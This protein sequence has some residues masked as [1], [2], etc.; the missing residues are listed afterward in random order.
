MSA[1]APRLAMRG[2]CK[3]FDGVQALDHVDLV[4]A[5]GS[6]HALMGENGA[7]KSTLM[8]VLAGACRADAGTIAID[9]RSVRIDTP[10]A[11]RAHGVSIVF[12]EPA[13]APNLRVDDNLFLGDEPRRFGSLPDR[14]AMRALA[15]PLLERLGCPFTLATRVEALGPAAQQQLE[16]ARALLHRATIL[17][18]DEPT[19]S[20]SQRETEVLFAR[21]AELKRAGVAIIYISHRMHEVEQLADRVSVLRD[22]RMAGTLE[23]EGL[24]LDAVVQRMVG[25][26]LHGLFPARPPVDAAARRVAFELRGFRDTGAGHVRDVSLTVHHGEVLGLAGLV[27][28]GR[29]ELARLVVG[30]DRRAAGGVRAGG[31][32]LSIR[33]PA[34][35]LAAGITYLAED[36]HRDGLFPEMSVPDNLTLSVVD[37]SARLGCLDRRRDA[38]T[39]RALI[40][41][42]AIKLARF[43]D[44]PRTLSGG[45]QQKVA[46]GRALSTAPRLLILDEPTR[47]VDVGAR[48]EIYALIRRLADDGVAVLLISSELAEILG[49]C[50]RVLVMREGAIEGEID[51]ARGDRLD[52]PSVLRLAFG[53]DTAR[54]AA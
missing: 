13:L 46:I 48:Q 9:G 4:V 39:A 24:S 37:A 6:V 2:I 42:L 8:K 43:D 10:H 27:G 22:G 45:N 25:R 35:A 5:A 52:E 47:G 51:P 53:S 41:R 40:E 30:A 11:A 33:T 26:S 20:L 19:T 14:A 23:R 54:A 44:T 12:Q 17:V 16:I 15:Q 49:L 3:R 28:S 29:T 38:A 32:A 7:G 36:R 1:A 31:E 21:I 18:L 34:D 50:D